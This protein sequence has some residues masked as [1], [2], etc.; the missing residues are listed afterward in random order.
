MFEIIHNYGNNMFDRLI[1]DHC[2]L[3]FLSDFLP[4]IGS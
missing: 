4:L 2:N 3:V 1:S